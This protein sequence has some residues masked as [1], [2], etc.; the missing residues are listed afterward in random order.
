MSGK[1]LAEKLV[2]IQPDL[3]VLFMSGYTENAIAHH[4]V[5]VPGIAFLQKP[6]SLTIIAAKIREVLAR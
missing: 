3:K 4:S 2:Q 5:L 1:S 6:F